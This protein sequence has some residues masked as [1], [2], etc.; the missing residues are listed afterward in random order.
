[1]LFKRHLP[2]SFRATSRISWGALVLLLLVTLSCS[3]KK[4][5]KPEEQFDPERSLARA[6]ELIEN[7]NYEEARKILLEVKNRD[8]TKKYAP[9][10]QLR[11]ADSYT[12]EDEVDLA[13]AEYKSFLEIYPDHKNAPYAQYQIAMAYFGQIA[14]PD[15]GYGAAAKALEEFEKLK[16]LYP[17][18]P[19]REV[20]DIKIETCR[21]TMADYEFLVGEYYFKKASYGAALGRL[22]GLLSKFPEY[23]KEP[24]VL[25]HIALCY[26]NIGNKDK[27][28]EYLNRLVEKYPNDALAKDAKKE[29][30]SISK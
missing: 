25:Y 12:K 23:K 8:V 18:N 24:I 26:K 9:I 17:R 28:T 2:G 10:A 6:N 20:V 11:I 14:G 1:M 3:G 15:Q 27:A 21:N 29:I 19:Y 7:K 16:R 4:E 22:E 13:V 30:A 5:I